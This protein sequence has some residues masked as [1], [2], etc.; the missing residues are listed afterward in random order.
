MASLQEH[1]ASP[2]VAG[3]K[4]KQTL[5][6]SSRLPDIAAPD[7]RGQRLLLLRWSGAFRMGLAAGCRKI[8]LRI[9]R[10]IG[11]SSEREIAVYARARVPKSL[12]RHFQIPPRHPQTRATPQYA[13][14]SG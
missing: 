8:W 10:S 14:A 11:L 3:S 13:V 7:Q 5:R 9:P 12:A 2:G 4:G 6:F 1:G